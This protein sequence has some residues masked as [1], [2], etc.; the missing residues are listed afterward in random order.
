[1]VGVVL[2]PPLRGAQREVHWTLSSFIIAV[3]WAILAF[4]VERQ[5]WSTSRAQ[6][7]THPRCVHSA[8]LQENLLSP[9]LSIGQA[10]IWDIVRSYNEQCLDW[11]CLIATGAIAIRLHASTCTQYTVIDYS[12]FVV[13]VWYW[14]AWVMCTC[15]NAEAIMHAGD[16]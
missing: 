9:H 2:G 11:M 12:T 5:L 13:Q 6:S 4:A 14:P 16:L 3:L 7:V 8:C 10:L 1:M 15:I